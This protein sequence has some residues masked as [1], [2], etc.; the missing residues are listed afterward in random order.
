MLTGDLR[1]QVDRLWDSFWSGGIANPISRVV[2]MSIRYNSTTLPLRTH[3]LME[4]LDCSHGWGSQLDD[5]YSC[6]DTPERGSFWKS[7]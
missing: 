6:F 7:H 2:A 3:I 4:W 1:N 5:L